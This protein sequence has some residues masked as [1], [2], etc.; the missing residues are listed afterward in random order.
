MQIIGNR[1]YLL[2]LVL[3]SLLNYIDQFQI[4]GALPKLK[5]YFNIPYSTLGFAESVFIIAFMFTSPIAGYLGDR[6][7]RKRIII[8]GLFS[9][10]LMTYLS[11]LAQKDSIE[12]FLVCRAFVGIGEACFV[13]VVPTI[14]TDLFEQKNRAIAFGVVSLTIPVGSGIGYITG[15]VISEHLGWKWAL[16]ITS[17]FGAIL[18]LISSIFFYD[19]EIGQNDNFLTKNTTSY[20]K[21]LK[22]L[23]TNKTYLLILLGSIGVTFSGGALGFWVPEY[24]QIVLQH[25]SPNIVTTICG[26]ILSCG[27]LAGISS[28]L[29]R[30]C[31]N[32]VTSLKETP[33]NFCLI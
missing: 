29:H 22:V 13:A 5:N 14:I 30:R 1:L 4:A 2:I 3:I 23:F 31:V 9:W 28:L 17:I 19:P 8:F 12:L 26:V 15:S 16:R 7:S 24:S 18:L 32:R 11:S 27:G 33:A 10:T 21:D 6:V 25:M 20:F